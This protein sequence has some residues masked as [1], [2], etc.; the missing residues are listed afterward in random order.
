MAGRRTRRNAR[1]AT[2][3]VDWDALLE[4]WAEQD[5]KNTMIELLKLQVQE[6]KN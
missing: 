3:T 4:L 5:A 6:L 2:I 1:Q